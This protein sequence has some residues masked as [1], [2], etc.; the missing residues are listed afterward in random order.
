MRLRFPQ[1]RRRLTLADTDRALKRLDELY[2]A[3]PGC[4]VMVSYDDA[5]HEDCIR[6]ASRSDQPVLV[7]R[8]KDLWV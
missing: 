4:L 2:A 1:R 6:R 7:V 3:N 5:E 8:A